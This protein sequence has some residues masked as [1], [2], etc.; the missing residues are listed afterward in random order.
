MSEREAFGRT[1]NKFQVLRHRIAQ[2]ASEIEATKQFVLYCCKLNDDGAYAVKECSMAKLLATEL[3]D[4]AAYQLLQFFGGNGF[5]EDFKA[6]RFF[7]DSRVGTIGGGSSE[8]MREIIAKMVI[9]DVDYKKAAIPSAESNGESIT[10][11]QNENKM[12]SILAL[13]Q[14]KAAAAP[15]LENTLKFDFGDEHL[16]I[17]GTGAANTVTTENNDADCT[18]SV[19]KEDLTAQKES[20]IPCRQS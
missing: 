5:M 8:I 1:I 9:D 17:D 4:K 11:H 16:F 15:A 12:E 20:W 2:L 19:E 6:A 14:A 13:I 3:S 10:H 18:I 7:R